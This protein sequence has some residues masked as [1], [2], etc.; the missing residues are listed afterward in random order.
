MSTIVIRYPKHETL[1]LETALGSASFQLTKAVSETLAGRVGLIDMGG[2][3]LS[4]IGYKNFQKLWIKG[5]FPRSY[6]ATSE[7][8]RP[9]TSVGWGGEKG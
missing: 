6:L 3:D 2:F 1:L 9:K 4:K 5:S 8:T 7:K